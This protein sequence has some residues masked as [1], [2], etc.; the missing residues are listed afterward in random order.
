MNKYEAAK[1]IILAIL[2]I[3]SGFFSWSLWTYQSNYET[4]EEKSYIKEVNINEKKEIKNIIKP[5]KV[6]YHFE[7]EH[8][9]TDSSLEMEKLIQYLSAWDYY[10]VQDI[11]SELT[12]EEFLSLV[13]GNKTIELIYPTLIPIEQFKNVINFEE[14]RLPNFQFDRIVI[15]IDEEN[16]ETGQIHFVAY[17]NRRIYIADVQP[18]LVSDLAENFY[19][20]ATKYPNYF[21]YNTGPR[22][23]FIVA[24]EPVYS[25]NKY[26]LNLLNV[27]LFR[28]ALFTNPNVVQKTFLNTEDEYTDTSTIMTANYSTRLLSYVNPMAETNV[29]FNANDLIQQG[30]DFINDHAGWT[31]SFYLDDVTGQKISFRLYVDGKPVFNN[32]GMSEIVQIWG[33]NEI[34]K[35]TRPYFT[36]DIL[37][38]SES[39][40]V[41]LPSGET[42]LSILENKPGFN[43][44]LLEML[45]PAYYMVK[46]SNEPRIIILKPVW[47]YRYNGV[48]GHITEDDF[49]GVINGL[50]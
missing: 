7:N 6:L 39:T 11:S 27:D 35:Y 43:P 21:S 10:K 49:G 28:D 24:E 22:T 14:K 46:D 33:A 13:H 37:L 48:W 26:L 3:A 16:Q 29:F 19:Y 12:D 20:P 15:K 2:V 18:Q 42:A 1:S 30:V 38:T 8:F 25:Q 31:D 45:S 50:E 23:L 5:S 4:L 47:N 34:Y 32:D 41:K 40:E 44:E 36:L 17:D 9:G